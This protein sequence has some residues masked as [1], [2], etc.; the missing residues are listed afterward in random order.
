MARK[1]PNPPP[2]DP[3]DE[4]YIESLAWHK[5]Y[6]KDARKVLNKGG[7]GAVQSRADGRGWWVECEGMTGTYQVSVRPDA[8]RG[9]VAECSCPSNKRPCKHA[10][11]L[12]L[13][14]AAHPEER[15]EPVAASAAQSFDLDALVRAVFADPREDTPRLVLADCVEELGRPARR[16]S[17]A[18]SARWRA[19]ARA[20]GGSSNSTRPNRS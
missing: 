10:L 18:Y 13:Y 14:L 15:I 6:V 9:F 7:F 2:A 5:D 12:L 8:E 16:R 20:T 11:A 3:W 17:S 4:A 1:K 19:S